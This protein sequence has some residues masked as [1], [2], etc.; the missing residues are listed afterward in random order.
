LLADRQRRLDSALDAEERFP[1]GRPDPYSEVR[2]ANFIDE[3]FADLTYTIECRSRICKLM[4]EEDVATWTRAFQEEAGERAL[5]DSQIWVGA[6]GPHFI[7]LA[8]EARSRGI[9]L[10]RR[11]S[12]RIR[13]STSVAYCR[14]RFPLAGDLFVAVDLDGA[15]RYAVTLRGSLVGTELANCV[16]MAVEAELAELTQIAIPPDT[17]L[18]DHHREFQIV[19]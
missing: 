16:R 7:E 3:V 9:L 18:D 17:V 6:D 12:R 10:S 2:L 14:R 8:E 11:I 19:P 1:R 15:D 13:E 5:T 4:V